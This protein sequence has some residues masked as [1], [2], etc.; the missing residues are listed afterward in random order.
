MQK[1]FFLIPIIFLTSCIALEQEIKR[2]FID[3]TFY[4]SNPNMAVKIADTFQKVDQNKRSAFST[5]IGRMT[6]SNIET[7][8]FKFHD[9]TKKAAFVIEIR[10]IRN[11]NGHWISNLNTRL[12]NHLE[13]DKVEKSGR[14]YYYTVYA[15]KDCNNKYYL[16][17]RFARLSGANDRTLI[18]YYY[19]HEIDSNADDFHKW[20]D[21]LRLDQDQKNLLLKFKND[22][23]K[24]IQFTDYKIPEKKSLN[25]QY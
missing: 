4:A 5:S 22:S 24:D 1:M 13:A 10:K 8:E 17:K 3:N 21:P 6:G 9:T 2:D 12:R 23:E 11:R 14:Q 25:A 18:N 20:Q 15:D 16:I 7:E 19:I